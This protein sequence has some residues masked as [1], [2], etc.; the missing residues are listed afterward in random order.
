MS[1]FIFY[2][3]G[4]AGSAELPIFVP[5]DVLAFGKYYNAALHC[6]SSVSIKDGRF[7][8]AMKVNATS[9]KKY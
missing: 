5:G 1:S 7:Q 3:R 4:R 8:S 9:K 2:Y 6:D